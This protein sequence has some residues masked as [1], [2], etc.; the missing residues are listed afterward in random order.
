MSRLLIVYHSHTGNTEAMAKAI[1]DG[2]A[3]AGAKVNLRKAA[4]ANAEDILDCDVVAFGTSNNF[5]YMSGIMKDFFDRVWLR[6]GDR[7]GDKHYATF[8]SAGG[9][10]R[11]AIESIEYICDLFSEWKQVSLK[12]SLEGI[13]ATGKPST[14]ILKECEEMGAKLARL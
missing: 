14:E 4:D 7:A 2:A 1:R 6:I 11:Q 13:A 8:S 10:G 12:K 5:H 9:G 3:S